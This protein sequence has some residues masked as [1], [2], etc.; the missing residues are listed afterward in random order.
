MMLKLGVKNRTKAATLAIKTGLQKEIDLGF[1]FR[2]WK[3]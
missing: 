1:L 3:K 2:S